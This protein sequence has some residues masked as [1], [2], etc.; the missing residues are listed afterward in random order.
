MPKEDID[1]VVR[2]WR[3]TPTDEYLANPHKGCCTFQRFNGDPLYPGTAWSEEGPLNGAQAPEA[4]I[5]IPGLKPPSVVRGYLPTTVAYCRWFWAKLE[6]EQGRYDFSMIDKALEACRE[7]DQTLAVRLMPFGFVSSG[8]PGLPAWYDS[9][10]PKVPYANWKEGVPNYNS[11]E[12]LELWGNLN[13]EFARRYDAHPLMES[14]DV[15]FLGPWGEGDGACNQKQIDRF[16]EMYRK[17]FVHTPRLA[18]IGGDPLTGDQLR[19]GIERGSGW[20]A[21]SFGDLGHDMAHPSPLHFR[22][23]HMYNCY[24][25]RLA[26]AGAQDAWKSAPVHAEVGLVPMEWRRL[27]HDIDFIIEQGYKYHLTYFMPKSTALPEPWM[28]KLAAFCEKIGYRF[29][30]RQATLSRRVRSGEKLVFRAWIENVG[31]APL[32]RRYDFALRFQQA[33]RK[34]IVS[35]DDVNVRAWLPGDVWIDRMISLPEGLQPG[36]VEVSA[37]LLDHVTR[38]PRVN[39]AI[40]ERFADRWALL[41]GFEVRG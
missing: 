20:R 41:G 23:N 40:K 27:G 36:W 34:Q 28:D 32:Y 10:F 31:V 33:D 14:V 1:D 18:L 38:Q 39:F 37:G 21:D 12:Y 16:A 25:R 15:A 19:A 5:G 30:F 24:P 35:F 17:A 3:Y 29:V 2:H 4:S 7:H 26:E 6:P 22:V 8:Q 9:R 11:A 13:R